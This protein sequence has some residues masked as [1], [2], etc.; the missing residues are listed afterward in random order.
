MEISA[1]SHARGR[2][3]MRLSAWAATD[4][5]ALEAGHE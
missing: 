1:V 3:S 4:D 5:G 2:C